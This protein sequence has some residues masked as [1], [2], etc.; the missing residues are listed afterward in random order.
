MIYQLVYS[1]FRTLFT[2]ISAVLLGIWNGKL[3]ST[4]WLLWFGDEKFTVKSRWPHYNQVLHWIA[5]NND[6]SRIFL[7]KSSEAMLQ[8]RDTGCRKNKAG[9]WVP[10]QMDRVNIHCHAMDSG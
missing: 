4:P 10:R 5:E 7:D 3:K 6:D 8:R 1:N 2:I 9:F